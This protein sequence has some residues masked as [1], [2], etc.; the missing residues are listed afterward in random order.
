ML[1][2]HAVV[3][4]PAFVAA[5]IGYSLGSLTLFSMTALAWEGLVFLAYGPPYYA[6][7]LLGFIGIRRLAQR[8][9]PIVYPRRLL[10]PLLA[11][12]AAALVLQILALENVASLP[13]RGTLLILYLLLLPSFMAGAA[14]GGTPAGSTPLHRSQGALVADGLLCVGLVVAVLAC[15]HVAPSIREAH[16]LAACAEAVAISAEVPPDDCRGP[17]I[18]VLRPDGSDISPITANSSSRAPA[19]SP[20]G[21]RLAIIDGTT[22][23][24]I[25]INGGDRVA[26]ATLSTNAGSPRW[27]PD[28]SSIVLHDYRETT[29]GD[30]LPEVFIVPSDG[31]R[32]P[33][34][35][36]QGAD[37]VWS[38]SGSG[39][40]FAVQGPESSELCVWNLA[41]A[42]TRCVAEVRGYIGHPDWSPDGELIAFATYGPEYEPS[43]I[44]TIRADG[45]ALVPRTAAGTRNPRWAPDGSAI[46][47]ERD[48]AE[49]NELCVLTL[50]NQAERCLARYWG[51]AETA[52]S[53]DS[54]H[55]V[56]AA[57]PD[58]GGDLVELYRVAR[59]GTSMIR[60]AWNNL[61]GT[62]AWSP[63]GSLIAIKG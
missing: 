55:V 31:S 23:V 12:Q 25:D 53:P 33:Q 48:G 30:L 57:H 38:P 63:D 54:R 49:L 26:L 42:S 3:S 27:S 52:W 28:G 61:I 1:R 37:P 15:W 20:D 47:F 5:Y 29:S 56:F 35:V 51:G 41:A 32:A 21:R 18:Y 17:A 13:I 40:L 22:L 45:T 44:Y 24:R 16:G 7:V 58:N 14:L 62:P 8:S 36:A 59:D 46:L 50:A 9:G 4:I 43:R 2:S 39:V 10:A 11:L 60:L 6:A 19:W 34:R